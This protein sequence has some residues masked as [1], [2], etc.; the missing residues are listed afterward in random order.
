VDGKEI[1]HSGD[2]CIIGPTGEILHSCENREELF[3]TILEPSLLLETR[4]R[5]PFLRDADGF[6][7]LSD[8]SPE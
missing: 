8:D 7:I 6:M 2:S 4:E 3:S 1:D 5:F